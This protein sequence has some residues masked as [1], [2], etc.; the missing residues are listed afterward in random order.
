MTI[1]TTNLSY[2]NSFLVIHDSSFRR[3]RLSGR[4][5]RLSA[6][7]GPQRGTDLVDAALLPAVVAL[8]A[9]RV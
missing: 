1:D 8:K 5:R 7:L 6:D 3:G 9:Q 2:F 4:S